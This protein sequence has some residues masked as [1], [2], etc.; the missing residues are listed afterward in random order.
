[1]ELYQLRLG[2][3]RHLDPLVD[4]V[5]RLMTRS[6]ELSQHYAVNRPEIQPLYHQ[7]MDN[8]PDFQRHVSAMATAQDQE[9]A[10]YHNREAIT[11]AMV[12]RTDILQIGKLAKE[13]ASLEQLELSRRFRLLVICMSI[14]F[15]MVINL[16]I[17]VLIRTSSMI[18]KPVDELME[19]SR[20]LA[21]EHFDYRVKLEH[22]DE[23]DDLARA[24]NHLAEQ[25]QAHEKRRLEM[26]GQVGLTLN[27][28]LNNA[29]AIIELQLSLMEK[30]AEGNAPL[31]KCL[32]QIHE[33]LD[34][35]TSTVAMLKQ[36]RRIVLTDYIPGQ[37]MLDLQQS[38]SEEP[39]STAKG[40]QSVTP[41]QQA[42]KQRGSA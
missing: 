3:S 18:L 28:E 32:R 12:L 19:A 42:K 35:M 31:E 1:M 9:F 25:L 29:I 37:K 15:L 5:D 8:L 7:F 11:A 21:A 2:Q 23:F 17:I 16:A 40:T 26:L 27:H 36:V 24:Y 34:R 39:Q 4:A 20:Q 14:G 22:E 38:A 30:R 13:H 10:A 6:R 41:D 33:N